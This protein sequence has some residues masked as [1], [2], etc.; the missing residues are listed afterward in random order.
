MKLKTIYLAKIA[1]IILLLFLIGLFY[2]IPFSVYIQDEFVQ[3][4]ELNDLIS[5]FC[6][7]NLVL[8]TQIAIFI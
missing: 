7:T 3:K 5:D 1:I 4:I 8:T 6:K 2:F